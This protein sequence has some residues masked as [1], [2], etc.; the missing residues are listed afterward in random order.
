M[1]QDQFQLKVAKRVTFCLV[2][3]PEIFRLLM[4]GKFDAYSLFCIR[5]PVYC[6]Q[7][8]G[9]SKLRRIFYGPDGMFEEA[10]SVIK[11]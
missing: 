5:S 10:R 6:S 11:S 3:P 8:Y 4:K 9:I 1:S 7:L 2:A